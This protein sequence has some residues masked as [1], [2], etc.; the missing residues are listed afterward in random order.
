MEQSELCIN[1][2]GKTSHVLLVLNVS[3]CEDYLLQA[4]G[5]V[6]VVLVHCFVFDTA[7]QLAVF[8]L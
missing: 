4:V 8:I 5:H 7:R 3:R 2:V 6:F 1:A